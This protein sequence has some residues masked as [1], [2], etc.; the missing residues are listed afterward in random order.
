[1]SDPTPRYRE[2]PVLPGTDE[3]HAWDVWG[4]DDELGSL[5]RIGPEQVRAAGA[6]IRT[7][8]VISLSLPLDE[9]KP[10]LFP[11][12]SAYR[13]VMTR[14]RTASDDMVDGLYL[15]SSSQWD[16]LGH[17][18]FRQHGYWGGRQ[19]ADL[20]GTGALGIDRWAEHGLIGR[21]VLADV[22]GHLAGQ[23][24]PVLPNERLAITPTLLDEVLAAQGSQLQAGDFLVVRTGWL[25]WFRSLDLGDRD[26]LVGTVG[27][28][29]RPLA[30]PGLDAAPDTAAYLWDHG[31][32]GVAA[33]NLAVEAIP[34]DPAIGF[35]HHRLIA[36]L[37]LA[38]GELWWL[39]ALA[40]S[41][42]RQGR[43][44]FFLTSGP[45]PVPGGAG[46]PAN[47]YALL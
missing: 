4:R 19:D 45:L 15:Q 31:V 32:A 39:D 34:V 14:T 25:E 16:A 18:R 12:R 2:L 44:E 22:A 1:M 8:Q 3:H 33:D 40:A 24:R 35:L 28:R 9:P 10:S 36:L 29:E 37:G 38:L 17:I 42:R 41:C 7:G 47:A 23:G 13:H 11:T 30:C 27:H 6:L 43:F 21:G 46:S 20:D 26:K 5:N